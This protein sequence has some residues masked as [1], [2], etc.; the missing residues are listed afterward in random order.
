MIGGAYADKI[1]VN[2]RE[3]I[4]RRIK[5]LD[6]DKTLYSWR[7]SR[8]SCGG[9]L[10]PKDDGHSARRVGDPR[11]QPARDLQRLYRAHRQSGAACRNRRHKK[12]RPGKNGPASFL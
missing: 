2:A 7:H 11:R 9:A 1:S 12:R 4:N 5:A 10:T 6:I 3:R 8:R